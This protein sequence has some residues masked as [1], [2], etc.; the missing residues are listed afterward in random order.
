MKIGI[1]TFHRAHNYGAVLQAYALQTVLVNMGH[2][3]FFIDYEPLALQKHYKCFKIERVITLNLVKGVKNLISEILAYPFRLQRANRFNQFLESN[4]KISPYIPDNVGTYDCVILGSDQIWSKTIT[5]TIDPVFFGKDFTKSSNVISYA[6][7]MKNEAISEI[8]KNTFSL[9][10]NELTTISVREKSIARLLSPLTRNKIE[11]V[12]DPTLL[13]T[14]REWKL[15]CKDIRVESEEYILVYQVSINEKANVLANRL[16]KEHNCK[17]INMSTSANFSTNKFQWTSPQHFVSLFLNA[18]YIVTTSFHGTA[19]SVIFNKPF[20]TIRHD[21]DSN[22]ER[23]VELLNK[24]NLNNRI[25]SDI[26]TIKSTDA[27]CW[28]EVNK[29][30]ETLRKHSI[31]FLQKSID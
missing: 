11:T 9:L 8:D 26:D 5:K 2:K 13:L 28:D 31:S 3:V 30:L 1:L 15:L 25:I 27:I 19:F 24:I 20:Y 23:V 21:V 22:N 29:N 12:L 10:L 18:K 17:V 6:A 7:S 16:A 14:H 4:M